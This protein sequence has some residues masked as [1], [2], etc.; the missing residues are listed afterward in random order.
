MEKQTLENIIGFS[1]AIAFVWELTEGWPVSFVSDGVRQLGYEPDD[2]LLSRVQYADI[3]HPD[4]VNK[5]GE[6][7]DRYI[8]SDL[9]S[10]E[11]SYRLITRDGQIR[12]IH[13]WTR[14]E[15]DHNGKALRTQGII[16][17]IT[18]SVLQKNKLLKFVDTVGSLY[19]AVDAEGCVTSVNKIT[20][21]TVE[22]SEYT[23]LGTNWIINF[24]PDDERQGV[25][26][27]LGEALSDKA[28][29]VFRY[30]NYIVSRSGKR[31]LID[32]TF[33]ANRNESGDIEDVIGFGK[34]ITDVQV[35]QQ[36]L[37]DITD[38]VP[39]AVLQYVANPDDSYSVDYISQGCMDIWELDQTTI[40]KNPSLLWEMILDDDVPGV[41]QSVSESG[42]SLTK[43]SHE[44]RIKTPSG[45]QKW[46]QGSGVPRQLP[47]GGILWN[48]FILDITDQ[49]ETRER[50]KASQLSYQ[51]LEKYDPLTGLPN[52]LLF[53][54]LLD[55]AI[56]AAHR[57]R[58]QL[59]VF[60]IDLDGFKQ[61]NDSYD[62]ATG[63]QVLMQVARRIEG[64][65][66]EVDTLARMGGDEF[67]LAMGNLKSA[68][69]AAILAQ[70]IIDLFQQPFEIGGLKFYLGAS[71]GIAIHPLHG[72][73]ADS[74]IRNADAAMYR[75]KEEGRLTYRYYTEALTEKAFEVVQMTNNLRSAIENNE[76]SV[77]YQPQFSCEDKSTI[78]FEALLRWHS[79][80]LGTIPPSKFIPLAEKSD[81]ILSLGEWVLKEACRQMKLWLNKGY[82]DG[83]AVMCVNVSGR[84]FNQHDLNEVVSRIL[85]ETGLP[86]ANLE[87]EITEST[88]VQ[89][90]EV[91]RQVLGG[92]RDIG[93]KVSIDDF[94]TGYSSLS[95]LKNLP[96]TKLKID[97]SFVRDLA[98][99]PN[100][101][102][103]A[104][105]IIALGNNMSLQV[106]AE[107]IETEAQ[108]K[109]L[110]DAG[111]HSGQG[112]WFSRPLPSAEIEA[113]IKAA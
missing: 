96:F 20:C 57:S 48:S 9:Q 40:E 88:V 12:W 10:F 47:S 3:I 84:Q 109:L 101:A 62:H 85:D 53:S 13:D 56:K 98:H 82:I 108:L 26:E 65:V 32:W 33:S 66:R 7:V 15:R 100:D 23:L 14:V 92:L 68:D 60:Y 34:D 64:V 71:I 74:L 21:E 75:A 80:E 27:A 50:L 36:R 35:M 69:D 8:H 83:N 97:Q 4:D 24:V 52:R 25:I 73:D 43:W 55:Q 49:L 28:N 95:Q 6:Q 58:Q 19:L 30:Q 31:H 79:P 67:T 87:L 112:Y 59:A 90:I 105:A 91:S 41:Q 17:D 45:K 16:L 99:D 38:N 22:E 39:L 72:T 103:I 77:H 86:S 89:S 46:L 51:Q 61:V 111:C 29:T 2:F 11:Q 104:S 1:P 42:Q 102:A 113:V 76:L 107:G 54:D 110:T 78:G 81:L 18:E 37:N 70:K 44:W 106:M 93:V 63:D 5:V 94:G